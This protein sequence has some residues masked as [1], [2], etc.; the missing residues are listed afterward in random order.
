MQGQWRVKMGRFLVL[1]VSGNF[2][3]LWFLIN[4][5]YEF[6]TSPVKAELNSQR[7]PV[8]MIFSKIDITN[9]G[10]KPN[11]RLS[12]TFCYNSSK[13]WRRPLQASMQFRKD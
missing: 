3:E 2:E 6:Q 5:F 12:A 1:F 7:T 11:K 8:A 9:T 13:N 10:D 4:N